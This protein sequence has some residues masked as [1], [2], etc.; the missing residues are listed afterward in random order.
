MRTIRSAG[1]SALP[2]ASGYDLLRQTEAE[3]AGKSQGCVQCHQ[4][5]GD[6]H[7]KRIDGKPIVRLGCTDCHGGDPLATT[8]DES[9]YPAEIP[10]GL[11]ALGQ[12]G[13]F[14]CLAEP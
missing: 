8:A 4:G 11:A 14:L 2:G 1:N 10:R 6:M 7:G 9:P 5:V 3:A 13:P 12:S